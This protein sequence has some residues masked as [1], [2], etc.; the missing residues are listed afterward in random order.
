MS[1]VDMPRRYELTQ[2]QWQAIDNLVPG[3]AGDR[4][5]TASDDRTFVNGVLW[6]LRTSTIHAQALTGTLRAAENIVDDGRDARP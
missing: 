5:R 6:V 1:E 3:K 4:G 2:A